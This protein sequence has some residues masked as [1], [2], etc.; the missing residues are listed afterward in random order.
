MT[1]ERVS[2]EILDQLIR[3][4]DGTAFFA[5]AETQAITLCLK[6][7]R[8]R[9]TAAEPRAP[10]ICGTP[11]AMCDTECMERAYRPLPVVNCGYVPTAS[12]YVIREGNE[13]GLWVACFLREEDAN[14][15]V[16][17]LTSEKSNDYPEFTIMRTPSTGESV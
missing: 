8:E 15:Y 14:R 6:E 3:Y 16:A 7:L 9:R 11:D 5:A 17:S 4:A 2:D 1:K 10:H 12:G 13:K